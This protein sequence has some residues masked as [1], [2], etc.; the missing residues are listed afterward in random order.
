MK[1]DLHVHTKY[2]ID[3]IIEPKALAAK[4]AALGIIPAITE[5]NNIDS[6]AA[7]RSLKADFISGEEIRTD[8]GDLIG[9]FLSENIPRKTPFAE[10]IDRIHEQGGLAYLPHMYDKSRKGVVPTEAEAQK[11]DIVEVF[12]ARCPLDS[13]NKK[14]GEFAK[15]HS[16]A[17]AVGSDSHFLME[18]GHNYVEVPDFDLDNPRKLMKA[19]KANPRHKTK[20]ATLLVRGTT[21]FVAIGKKLLRGPVLNK[22]F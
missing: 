11:L 21:T 14:A 4:S 7:M 6:H 2:S 5:H 16:L 9:L 8:R 12:N 13:F 3:S 10:A 15:K 20:K 1:I 22:F 18:F 17:E 19:L